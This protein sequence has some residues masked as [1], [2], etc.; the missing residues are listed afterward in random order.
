M[1]M[2]E[3]GKSLRVAVIVLAVSALLC[4]ALGAGISVV[5]QWVNRPRNVDATKGPLDKRWIPLAG[6]AG[7]VCREGTVVTLRGDALRGGAPWEYSL[8]SE[9]RFACNRI[10]LLVDSEET[11]NY[12]LEHDE[13]VSAAIRDFFNI[14]L[15][16][17]RFTSDETYPLA[18]HRKVVL[19]V[20]RDVSP[21]HI[22]NIYF[23]RLA[24][25][26]LD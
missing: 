22:L 4:A 21:G 20:N 5:R 19:Y 9:G 12:I 8:D 18:I 17:E 13:T 7:I 2:A 23:E 25:V 24:F 10:V 26:S 6:L 3:R 15:R 11:A 14:Q 1:N 16:V